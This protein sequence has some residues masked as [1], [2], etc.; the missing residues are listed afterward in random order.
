[1]R[2]KMENNS[3]YYKGFTEGALV[4]LLPALFCF[5]CMNDKNIFVHLSNCKSNNYNGERERVQSIMTAKDELILL[6]SL[7]CD[8]SFH[9]AGHIWSSNKGTLIILK[10]S[11]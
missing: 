1:M 11:V 8:E 9:A 3:D 4:M 2:L 7:I 10:Y 5:V 6:S